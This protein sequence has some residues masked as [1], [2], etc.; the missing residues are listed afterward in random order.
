MA[1]FIIGAPGIFVIVENT[2]AGD[3]RMK[4]RTKLRDSSDNR[5]NKLTEF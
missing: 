3:D 2:L 5:S 4:G 1:M